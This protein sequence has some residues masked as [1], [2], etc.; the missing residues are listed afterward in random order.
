M[1]T[2]EIT[3]KSSPDTEKIPESTDEEVEMAIKSMNRHK[4][5]GMDG[6]GSDIMKLGNNLSSPT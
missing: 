4:A 3:I 1:P 2:T 6:T 5:H